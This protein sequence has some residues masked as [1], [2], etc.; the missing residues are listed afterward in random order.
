MKIDKIMLSIFTKD[1]KVIRVSIDSIMIYIVSLL[2]VAPYVFIGLSKVTSTRED[3]VVKAEVTNKVEKKLIIPQKVSPPIKQEVKLAES[4]LNKN[5]RYKYN[6]LKVTENNGS[7]DMTFLLSK[8][9]PDSKIA[10]GIV[11]VE[12]L[13]TNGSILATSAKSSFKFQT[14]RISNFK[15]AIPTNLKISNLKL[16]IVEDGNES[17]TIIKF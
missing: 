17:F 10:S 2:I 9:I 5:F 15:I 4:S 7:L 3:R 6:D 14:A 1:E 16:K 8:K 13:D 12:A 11:Y